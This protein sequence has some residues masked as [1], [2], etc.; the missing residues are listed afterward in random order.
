MRLDS[1]FY[2]LAYRLGRPR[3]DTDQPR[4]ELKEVL[5][6]RP[7]GRALDLG[8]GT[9]TDARYLAEQGW[10]VVGV[11]F[12]PQAI[13]TAK[14]RVLNTGSPVR[15]VVGDVTNLRGVG[16]DGPFDLLVDVGCYHAIPDGLREAYAA[17]VAGVARSGADF[18][19]AG[20]S[21]PRRC[22]ACW[23]LEA[24]PLPS[25]ASAS[26]QTST[27]QVSDR[28]VL[29]AGRRGSSSSTWCASDPKSD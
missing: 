15:F 1:L 6:G 17:G 9:G 12:V 13:D 21:I 19:L 29:W 11:D 22:G 5:E 23:V 2:R 25:S 24:S 4:P 20:I 26:E 3:W 7:A 27:W 10:E 14:A 8:C 18:Y 28:L 16:I